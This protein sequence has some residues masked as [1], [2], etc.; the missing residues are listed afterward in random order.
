M[1]FRSAGGDSLIPSRDGV[2]SPLFG[3]RKENTEGGGKMLSLSGFCQG[4]LVLDRLLAL[5]AMAFATFF[6][7]LGFHPHAPCFALAATFFVGNARKGI[8]ERPAT[9]R[10][11]SLD[12]LLFLLFTLWSREFLFPVVT[13]YSRHFCSLSSFLSLWIIMRRHGGR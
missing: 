10:P 8:A 1:F 9:E 2:S 6:L 3:R 11:T 5:W 7:V 4:F 12:R 13:D